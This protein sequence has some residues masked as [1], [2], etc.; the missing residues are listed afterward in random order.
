MNDIDKPI[1]D[2]EINELIKIGKQ[3]SNTDI[4]YI[5][6]NIQDIELNFDQSTQ[7][8]IHSYFSIIHQ[9]FNR[10]VYSKSDIS[11]I[12]IGTIVGEVYLR[13]GIE[14][15]YG[16]VTATRGLIRILEKEAPLRAKVIKKW[17]HRFGF[18]NDFFDQ[19]QYYN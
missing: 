17:A 2:D 7:S 4:D 9:K 6:N 3:Y 1:M 14:F 15:G 13:G 8:N 16:S 18:V 10:G 5:K 19:Q 12:L 11:Y